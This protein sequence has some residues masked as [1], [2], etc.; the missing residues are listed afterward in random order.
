MATVHALLRAYQHVHT[1]RIQFGPLSWVTDIVLTHVVQSVTRLDMKLQHLVWETE[2]PDDVYTYGG[3]VGPHA[4]LLGLNWTDDDLVLC[5]EALV[6]KYSLRTFVLERFVMVTR[7]FPWT[8]FAET[9]HALRKIQL[10]FLFDGEGNCVLDALA[11]LKC[12]EYVA[13][14]HSYMTF[15]VVSAFGKEQ[16]FLDALTKFTQSCVHVKYLSLGGLSVLDRIPDLYV[17]LRIVS[18]LP[19]LSTLELSMDFFRDPVQTP[20]TVLTFP[21]LKHLYL[22]EPY[23]Q[24]AL[25]NVISSLWLPELQYG[26]DISP[27]WMPEM[28]QRFLQNAPKLRALRLLL[29]DDYVAFNNV[30]AIASGKWPSPKSL[31]IQ[32]GTLIHTIT[33]G[34][35]DK[36]QNACPNAT[37]NIEVVDTV[38]L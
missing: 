24:T 2:R 15:D 11:N 7:F 14:D 20:T 30:N 27:S 10:T 22:K 28:L 23:I 35:M 31:H 34:D 18:A 9:Q 33:P 4:S 32:V 37:I 38:T 12:V 19:R 5:I 21:S 25:V 36:L 13:V 17:F 26:M 8:V 16:R 29:V 6:H 3:N 1:L